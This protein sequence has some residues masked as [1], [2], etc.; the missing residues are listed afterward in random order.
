VVAVM[1]AAVG[2]GTAAAGENTSTVTTWL[3]TIFSVGAIM[4]AFGRITR[5]NCELRA[6]REQLAPL[7][8]S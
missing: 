3:L 5:T 2:I 6:G 8:V 1:A 7:A 4:A